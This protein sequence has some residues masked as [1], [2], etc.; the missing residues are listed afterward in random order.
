MEVATRAV[1]ELLSLD[2]VYLDFA[3]AFDEVPRKR[4]VKKL[5]AHG[6]DGPL[7]TWI[8]AWLTGREHRVVINVEC[9]EW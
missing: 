1:N 4:L 3:K 2:V 8:E 5:Q 6:I 7:L 9:S